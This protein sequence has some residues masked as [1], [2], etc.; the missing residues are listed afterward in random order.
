MFSVLFLI[1]FKLGPEED[2]GEGSEGDGDDD[3]DEADEDGL[4]RLLDLYLV[5]T[6]NHVLNLFL[7]TLQGSALHYL[8]HC[9]LTVSKVLIMS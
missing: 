6:T 1:A 9:V 7:C 5:G 3:I 4:V 2:E 8:S